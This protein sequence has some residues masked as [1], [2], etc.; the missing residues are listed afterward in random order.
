MTFEQ[1]ASVSPIEQFGL[2]RLGYKIVDV[3]QGLKLNYSGGYL[4]VVSTTDIFPSATLSV[5][6][7]RLMY[8]KQPSFE[9]THKAPV[10]MSSYGTSLGYDLKYYPATMYFR[11]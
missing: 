8:Y 7:I 11:K 10:L 2:N 6:G 1:H 5:N 4:S 9:E 3:A